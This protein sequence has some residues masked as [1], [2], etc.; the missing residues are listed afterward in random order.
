MAVKVNINKEM[1]LKHRFW[2]MIGVAAF[3]S[4]VG[5]LFLEFADDAEAARKKLTTEWTVA[6]K[7]KPL[8]NDKTREYLETKANIAKGLENTIWKSAYEA[9]RV[10]FQWPKNIEDSYK[11]YDG[12]F[13]IDVKMDKAPASEKEWPADPPA[14]S[15]TMIGTLLKVDNVSFTIQLR[16]GKPQRFGKTRSID[17]VTIERQKKSYNAMNNQKGLVTVTFQKGRYFGD[18]LTSEERNAFIDSYETQIHEILRQVDPLSDKGGV[19]QLKG[20]T[21]RSDSLPG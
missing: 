15:N 19:V 1:I 7:K 14:D 3:L 6:S 4:L 13:A 18:L 11:F 8:Y 5:I 20:W 21:Y 9:Q 2:I 17:Q 16:D 12:L 10:M